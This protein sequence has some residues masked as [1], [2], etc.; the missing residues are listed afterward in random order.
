MK[1]FEIFQKC[2]TGFLIVYSGALLEIRNRN[3]LEF[4]N[5]LNN[6]QYLSGLLIIIIGRTDTDVFDWDNLFEILTKSSPTSL[7]K[8]KFYS[9]FKPS[10]LE[11]FFDN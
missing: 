10:K 9:R 1:L 6:C 7:F 5:L 8:F 11:S 2:T 4:E 3:I